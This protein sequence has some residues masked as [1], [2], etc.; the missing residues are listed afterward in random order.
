MGN[1]HSSDSS[2]LIDTKVCLEVVNLLSKRDLSSDDMIIVLLVILYEIAK[3]KSVSPE[4][5][6]EDYKNIFLSIEGSYS[7]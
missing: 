3:A 6:I 4:K 1:I 2:T 7:N 5:A